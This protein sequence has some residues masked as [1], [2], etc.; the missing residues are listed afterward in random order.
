[1]NL[2]KAQNAGVRQFYKQEI[3]LFMSSAK[4]LESMGPQNVDM[5]Y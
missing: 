2:R 1:M 3:A 5:G 4:Y